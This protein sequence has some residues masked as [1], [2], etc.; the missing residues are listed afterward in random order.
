MI[1]LLADIRLAVRGLQRSA[2]FT[3]VAVLTLALGIGATTAI[4]SVVNAVLIQPLP[5]PDAEE[6]LSVNFEA[7]GM[8]YPFV[9]FSD[10]AFLFVRDR[11]Q[12]LAALAMYNTHSVNLVA[13]GEPIRVAGAN[14]TP[15]LF[16]VL[17]IPAAMGRTFTSE[18]GTPG[19]APVALIAHELWLERYGG[20]SAIL[21]QVVDMD[22]VMRQIVG[23]MPPGFTFPGTNTRIWKPFELDETSFS[24]GSFSHPGVG[25]MRPGTDAATVE[26]DI[27][28]VMVRMFEEYADAFPPNFAEQA[29][30]APRVVDLKELAV[31]DIR[32]ALFVVLGTVSLVLLIACANVGNLFLVRAEMRQRE[33]TLRAALGAGRTD[34]ARFFLAESLIL[35]ITGGVLGVVL[36]FLAVRAFTTLAPVA[37]PRLTEISIDATVLLFTL[38]VSL[39]AGIAFGAIPLLRRQLRDLASSL[40]EGGRSVTV[41]QGPFSLRNLLV[42]SQIALAL[43]LLVGSGLMMRSFQAL[44]EVNPGF[45]ADGVLTASIALPRSEYPDA[46]ERLALWVSLRD[47]VAG[48]PGVTSAGVVDNLPM[49]TSRSAGSFTIEGLVPEEGALPPSA[50][51]KSVTAGYFETLQIPL[52][53]GRYLDDGDGV[54]RFRA[55]VVS[56]NLAAHWWPTA[57]AIGKRISENGG[58]DEPTW[59]EIVGVVGNVHNE[60]LEDPAEHTIYYPIMAGAAEAPDVSW[61]NTL[62]IRTE[63]SPT[64][65]LPGVRGV[66]SELDA[67]LPIARSRPLAEHLADT[68]ARTSFTL[69]MLGIAASVALFLGAIGI[70]GVISYVVS[71]RT[72]EIGVRIALGASRG[73][74]QN[75][76]V[77]RGMLLASVGIVVGLVG[78]FAATT[79]LGSLLYEVDA[80]D[81]TTYAAVAVALAL[82]ALLASWI[83]AMRASG[84]DPIVALRSD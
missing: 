20:D 27:E 31:G 40:R 58:A 68:M 71:Q 81:P 39:A 60:T 1:R 14:V 73:S 76:V 29:G 26:S 2:T 47:R 84:V 24:M 12:S 36:A 48:L 56:A 11:Q 16:D 52:L 83:P 57:G 8:G 10:G 6:L 41:S 17:Q 25:R 75:M 18:E 45:A 37:L 51:K 35:A 50:E 61:N 54:D 3:V 63:G 33:V 7:P 49:G 67:R 69:V 23:V 34:I 4:F 53:Q 32:Q 64:G 77:R 13:D 21:G 19:A 79:A 82:T 9:P 74:V 22:G 62:I 15:S 5:Y 43:V 42:V 70:Y 28:A 44:R 72:S 55:A 46:E 38:A 30:F 65:L 59:Y 78:A 66:V 80:L